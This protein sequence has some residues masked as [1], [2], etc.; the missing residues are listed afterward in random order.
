MAKYIVNAESDLYLVGDMTNWDFDM[1]YRFNDLSKTTETFN[2]IFDESHIGQTFIL[3]DKKGNVILNGYNELFAEN[4]NFRLAENGA[5]EV[6]SAGTFKFSYN[7]NTQ[8]LK[9]E[10]ISEPRFFY[11]FRNGNN[12]YTY[13]VKLNK[14]TNLFE[15]EYNAMNGSAIQ[16]QYAGKYI[17]VLDAKVTGN[18]AKGKTTNKLLYTLEGNNTVFFFGNA[19]KTK[20]A[21]TYNPKTNELDIQLK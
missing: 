19:N 2:A 8:K 12:C 1:D 4:E 18:Y 10:K 11:V 20:F 21:I 17:S 6:L 9:C 13:E 15:F 7:T 5:I 3:T 14:K 16:F